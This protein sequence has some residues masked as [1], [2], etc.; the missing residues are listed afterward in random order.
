M[1]LRYLFAIVFCLT[2]L[3]YFSSFW[4]KFVWDDEQFIYK[5]AFV[6]N[7]DFKA[8][9]TTS[10]TAGAGINSNYYRP[11]TTLSF[12]IDT[13]LWGLKEFPFHVTNTFFHALNAVLLIYLLFLLGFSKKIS[14]WV[15]ALFAVHPIQTEAVTYINS[16]GDSLYTF[17]GLIS[18]LCLLF[19]LRK[20]QPQFKLYNLSYKISSYVLVALMVVTYGASIL[21]KE[22]GITIVGLQAL[23]ITFAFCKKISQKPLNFIRTHAAAFIGL[24]SCIFIALAYLILRATILNFSSS[25]NFYVDDSLYA[26]SLYIR[27]LTFSKVIWQYFSLLV[28]PYP[29]HMERN[30]N[31]VTSILSF[32]PVLTLVGL[33]ILIVS[34]LYEFRRKKTFIILFGSA[35]SFITL[36]PVSGIIPINGIMYEHWL[37]TPMIGFFI[38][39]LGIYTVFLPPTFKR[40]I[41]L[42]AHKILGVFLIVCISLTIRQN[43]FWSTPIRL[44]EYL[45]NYTSS[46]RIHNNLGMA[47]AENNQYEKAITE[48]KKSLE[49]DPESAF[50]YHNLGN[51]FNAQGKKSDAINSY[52]KALSIDPD[53]FYTFVPLTRTYIELK[54]YKE[55]FATLKTAQKVVYTDP[56]Y[57]Y[58]ELQLA[59]QLGD[60]E[61]VQ[62]ISDEI[63]HAFPNKQ[64]LLREAERI[65]KAKLPDP[66]VY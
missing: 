15:G 12:A 36:L 48:Y 45:L 4:N 56:L 34:V 1:R 11:F 46:A 6:Q 30:V 18:L 23:I 59:Y 17:Y 32:W 41:S 33:C 44:Y 9:F 35:W 63:M 7:F 5:N 16:R 8:I 22:I 65:E 26:N 21:S 57:Y 51:V 38:A 53:F 39:L 2:F 61:R 49:I 55:A 43:Y 54:K 40:N 66:T 28:F 47:Y 60:G 37:Y 64:N 58:I 52:E 29:L 42:H 27:L 14:F 3:T 50:V 25:F 20:L 13:A 10:T 24:I 31:L 19:L 62:N